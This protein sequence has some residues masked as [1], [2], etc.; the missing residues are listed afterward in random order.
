[1]V[2]N[3]ALRGA[4]R[5]HLPVGPL[6]YT[7]PGAVKRLDGASSIEARRTTRYELRMVR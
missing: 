1:M 6:L 3:G 4:D 7:D 5:E 2:R